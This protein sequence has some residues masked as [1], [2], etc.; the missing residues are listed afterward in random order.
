MA[1]RVKIDDEPLQFVDR[2]RGRRTHLLQ[3][4]TG[5]FVVRRRGGWFAYHLACAVDD[6]DAVGEVVRG[7]DLL[8][9]TAAQIYL[10]RLLRLPTPAYAHLPVALGEHGNKLSKQTFAPPLRDDEPLAQLGAAWS[11]LGQTPPV[12]KPANVAEFW[13][14]ALSSWNMS[15]VPRE[16][17]LSPAPNRA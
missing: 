7:A 5:D 12:E 15:A 8:P 14:H 1:H 3:E 11:F 13:Q 4:E 9:G 17:A 6:A 10:Q 2:I 16:D